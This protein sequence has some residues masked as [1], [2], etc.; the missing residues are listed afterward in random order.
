MEGGRWGD[1]FFLTFGKSCVC[2]MGR[3]TLKCL[4]VCGEQQLSQLP[5]CCRSVLGAGQEETAVATCGDDLIS[6]WA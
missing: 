5:V 1:A 3:I 4:C 6:Q 2:V